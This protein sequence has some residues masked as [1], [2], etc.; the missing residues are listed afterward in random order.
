MKPTSKRELQAS[1]PDALKNVALGGG[2]IGSPTEKMV[3]A[4]GIEPTT[5]CLNVKQLKSMVS[6]TSRH[7]Q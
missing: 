5:Y 6:A 4:V 3:S 1:F 7:A 2:N